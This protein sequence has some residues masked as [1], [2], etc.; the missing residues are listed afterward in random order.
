MKFRL[1]KRLPIVILLIVIMP[2]T[3]LLTY[4]MLR[5]KKPSFKK[6]KIEFP[7]YVYSDYGLSKRLHFKPSGRM[8]DTLAMRMWGNCRQ[9]P[10]AGQSCIKIVYDIYNSTAGPNDLL[11]KWAGIFW[12]NPPNNWGIF[13][14]QGYDLRKSK[15]LV[16]F[17]K[18]D[19]GGEKVEFFMGGISGRY[20]DSGQSERKEFELTRE[21]KRYEIP[22]SNVNLKYIIGGFGLSVSGDTN[23]EGAI[24]YLDEIYYADL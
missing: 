24:F 11:H 17:A 13:P 15:R 18:G 1:R 7:F 5:V 22:L 19:K 23:Q 10:Y 16:F 4:S 8:G 9:E 6:E 2:I 12:N 14:N 20:G 3:L 21:W